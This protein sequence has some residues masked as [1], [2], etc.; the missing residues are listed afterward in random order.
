[1]RKVTVPVDMSSEQKTILGILSKRQLTYLAVAGVLIYFYGPFFYRMAPTFYLGVAF[2]VL[3]ALPTAALTIMLAFVRK[4]KMGM[5]FDRYLLTKMGHK[6]E[7]G[8]WRKGT[9]AKEWMV[10]QK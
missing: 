2:F 5:Y 10:K 1:M 3:S 9:H 7:V 4:E 6:N 8:L